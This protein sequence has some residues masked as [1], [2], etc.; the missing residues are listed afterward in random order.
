M[1]R[2]PLVTSEYNIQ[3]SA[4]NVKHF[5]QCTMLQWQYNT[6]YT[7]QYTVK[8]KSLPEPSLAY[9]KS[10]LLSLSELLRGRF[11]PL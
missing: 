2:Y 8:D 9:C 6:Q 5:N 4:V 3:L 1:H 11:E 10:Y 7:G